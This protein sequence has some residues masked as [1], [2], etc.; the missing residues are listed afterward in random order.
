MNLLQ[1]ITS[2]LAAVK[3]ESPEA[4]ARLIIEH[5]Y[6]NNMFM[7]VSDADLSK[8][9]NVLERRKKHE[10]VQYILGKA[11]FFNSGNTGCSH[12]SVYCA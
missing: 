2:E 12:A 8:F 10:P 1:Y 9:Q 11:F 7:Q 6:N 3:V 5:L 4:E